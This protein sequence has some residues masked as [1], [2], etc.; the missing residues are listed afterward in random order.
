MDDVEAMELGTS[1]KKIDLK[2]KIGIENREAGDVDEIE[3]EKEGRN[4]NLR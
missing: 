1:I 4:L 2:K 3:F